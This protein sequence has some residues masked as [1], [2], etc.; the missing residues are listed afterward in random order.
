MRGEWNSANGRLGEP[1]Y[2]GNPTVLHTPFAKSGRPRPATVGIGVNLT[3][4]P[5]S[6][7]VIIPFF[8]RHRVCRNPCTDPNSTRPYP[9]WR[10][11]M[12]KRTR[13]FPHRQ[14]QLQHSGA[15]FSPRGY[16]L[17]VWRRIQVAGRKDGSGSW[18]TPLGPAKQPRCWRRFRVFLAEYQSPPGRPSGTS[19]Y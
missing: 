6:R 8:C 3:V 2:P 10:R 12:A 18:S 16:F 17:S 15:F 11:W 9:K 1:R 19:T 14:W 4:Q 13:A 5:N 7:A